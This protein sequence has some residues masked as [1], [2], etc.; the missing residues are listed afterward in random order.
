MLAIPLDAK[1]ATTISELYGNVE[2]FALLDTVN[3][4]FK[5]IENKVKGNG[6]KSAEFLK[7]QGATSTIFFHMGEGVYNSCINNGIKV[8]SIEHAKDSI[9]AIYQSYKH[10]NLSIVDKDNYKSKLD[11]GS[12]GECKC[13]CD[14]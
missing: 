13:G 5:V 14:N 10:G 4:Y 6:P 9:D 1:N 3:G 12:S 11:P 8:F 2:F 7:D